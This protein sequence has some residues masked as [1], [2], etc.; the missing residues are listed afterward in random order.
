M[1]VG[2]QCCGKFTMVGEVQWCGSVVAE[3]LGNL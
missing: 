3:K 2:L 1:Q